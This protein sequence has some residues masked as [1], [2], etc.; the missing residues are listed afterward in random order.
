MSKR[1]TSLLPIWTRRWGVIALL[2]TTGFVLGHPVG[3]V[4]E[5]RL[6]NVSVGIQGNYQV[7]S[8]TAL[9][10]DVESDSWPVTVAVRVADPDGNLTRQPSEPVSKPASGPAQVRTIFKVGRLTDSD[11]LDKAAGF[12]GLLRVDVETP[13]EVTSLYLT[14]VESQTENH[15]HVAA[16]RDA[17]TRKTQLWATLGE[18]EGFRQ[19]AERIIDRG[20]DLRLPVHLIQLDSASALPT[21]E[22]GLD[23]L[24]TLIVTGREAISPEADAAIRRW[25]S[26]GGHLIVSVGTPA[27]YSALSM[28]GWIPADVEEESSGLRDLS[29]LTTQL[30]G[31][32]PIRATRTSALRFSFSHGEVVAATLDGPLWARL[33]YGFG[34]V[35]LLGVDLSRPP[36]V[37]WESLPLL[38]EKLVGYRRV[39]E[40]RSQRTATAQLS[41]SGVSELHTQLVTGLDQFPTSEKPTSWFAMGMII[42]YLLVIGPLDY[43][44]V[45]KLLRR[46]HWTWV[47][48][49]IVVVAAAGV[50]AGTAQERNPDA[51]IANQV[52]L[53]DFNGEAG[54]ARVHSWT[55]FTSPSTDRYEVHAE[56]PGGIFVSGDAENATGRV[57][58]SGIPETGF[59]GMYRTGGLDQW[60]AEYSFTP[61]RDAISDLPVSIWSSASVSAEWNDLPSALERVL[62]ARLWTSGGQLNG[63]MTNRFSL[64]LQDWFLAHE[65]RAYIPQ[66]RTLG[67]E[68]LRIAP[69]EVIDL[70]NR[71]RV[72]PRVLQSF[73]TGVRRVQVDSDG[74]RPGKDVVATRDTWDPLVRDPFHVLRMV[75]FFEAGNGDQFT[76][77]ENHS[78]DRLDLSSQ[79]DLDR[80]ILFC[81]VDAA[82]V[83]FAVNEATLEPADHETILRIVLPVE[84]R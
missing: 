35:T 69:G 56:L 3:A 75:T 14:S 77:L 18:S 8:W 65:G 80:A 40:Q 22:D 26:G 24:H 23:G 64:P 79:L 66:T 48:F 30:P 76:S 34:K 16:L 46:P 17:W 20:D 11:D 10:A 67:A 43:L 36:L 74:D 45:H 81:R 13:E 28:S 15:V 63:Q 60:K 62:E 6:S 9:E 83:A 19:A 32:V 53:V 44:I 54:T 29:N 59:R 37:G 49:P 41:E 71:R 1:F 70:S 27:D 78:F 52:D 51:A 5:V 42:L 38:C 2:C 55:A 61:N 47:T 12:Q 33:P 4:A 25:V 50:A 73:L 72:V 31:S 82:A 58:W 57:S 39:M 84:T 68:A 21:I 7:G